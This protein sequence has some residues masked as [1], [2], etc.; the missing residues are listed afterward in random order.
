MR[1][2]AHLIAAGVLGPV[3]HV[4]WYRTDWL[5]YDVERIRSVRYLTDPR[6]PPRQTQGRVDSCE[7]LSGAEA[8]LVGRRGRGGLGRVVVLVPV[9]TGTGV[10]RGIHVN[11]R[12]EDVRE[13]VEGPYDFG[14]GRA[15]NAPVHGA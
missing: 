8:Q 12:G 5:R 4:S 13:R 10:R 1:V 2:H 9:F 14:D 3:Q 7:A 11:M 6:T 15:G